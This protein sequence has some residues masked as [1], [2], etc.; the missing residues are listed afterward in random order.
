[1]SELG[2][3]KQQINHE[4]PKI[5]REKVELTN[6]RNEDLRF[7]KAVIGKRATSKFLAGLLKKKGF[8]R[9]ADFITSLCKL[10][11]DFAITTRKMLR[12]YFS[13]DSKL[14][15]ED[16]R[17]DIICKQS[18]ECDKLTGPMGL[19]MKKLSPKTIFDPVE[20]E[21]LMIVGDALFPNYREHID[22]LS[23]SVNYILSKTSLEKLRAKLYAELLELDPDLV[24]SFHTHPAYA[25][26]YLM[27]GKLGYFK[28]DFK[29]SRTLK[30]H[31]FSIELKLDSKYGEED[32]ALAPF[33]LNTHTDQILLADAHVLKHNKHP[34]HFI[35]KGKAYSNHRHV[36]QYT[37]VA[38]NAEERDKWVESL[39]RFRKSREN[40]SMNTALV[41]NFMLSFVR[42]LENR[43]WNGM[44]EVA[45]KLA[46][47]VKEDIG[48]MRPAVPM[49]LRSSLYKA[50][51][52]EMWNDD[53]FKQCCSWFQLMTVAAVED[54]KVYHEHFDI[55]KEEEAA[56]QTQ[57]KKAGCMMM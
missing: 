20:K 12:T 30:Y 41:I 35:V 55:K 43:D 32:K 9:E 26:R 51:G 21:T 34:D 46:H 53:A 29:H 28:R 52:N 16:S 8:Y 50:A 56:S 1:M 23:E 24:A 10:R 38:N 33:V 7:Y 40:A 37:L 13:S 4:Q 15:L 3:I 6:E 25:E 5:F 31:R 45:E 49:C 14:K 44:E 19:T 27:S 22:K 57:K 39:S 36:H 47:H 42:A 2:S 54:L 18:I 11:F 48:S 17:Y